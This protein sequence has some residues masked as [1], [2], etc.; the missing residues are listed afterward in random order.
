MKNNNKINV[1]NRT[2][3]KIIVT[4]KSKDNTLFNIYKI[5]K[6]LY[7]LENK[8]KIQQQI[9]RKTSQQKQS[10]RYQTHSNLPNYQTHSNRLNS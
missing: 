4:C 2:V 9:P 3:N 1:I 10:S 7:I 6:S 5:A 8:M